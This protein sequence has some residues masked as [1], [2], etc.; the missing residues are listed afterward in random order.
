MP[1]IPDVTSLG[2]RPTPDS[3]RGVYRP[4]QSQA[5]RG[6]M[7]AG[8]A[9]QNTGAELQ[10]NVDKFNY[11][12]AKSDYLTKSLELDTQ[13]QNDTD[14]KTLPDRY[15][16]AQ[17]NIQSNILSQLPDERLRSELSLE[18]QTDMA[19]Q[20]AAIRQRANSLWKE[21]ELGQAVTQNDALKKAYARTK[22]P[23]YLTNVKERWEGLRDV[24]IISADVAAQ[25]M[26]SDADEMIINRGKVEPASFRAGLLN[27]FSS[28]MQPE[29]YAKA[30][31]AIS[32]VVDKLEDDGRGTVTYDT[33]GMTKYGISKKWNEDVDVENLTKE[34]AKKILK[35]RYWDAA[36]IDM[37]PD[38]MKLLVFDAAVNQGPE[39]ALTMA[40]MSGN[41]PEKFIGLRRSR[42][43]QLAANNPDTYGKYLKGW[44]NRLDKLSEKDSRYIPAGDVYDNLSPEKIMALAESGIADQKSNLVQTIRSEM[45]FADDNV[46]RAAKQQYRD[47]S[48]VVSAIEAIDKEL[49]DDP[50]GYAAQ[51][52]AMIE[53]YN[54]L[55]ES[56]SP[57]AR[58]K[59]FDA[60][61]S[62]QIRQGVAEQNVRYA[63]KEV[64][65][66]FKSTVNSE[67]ATSSSV[68]K[69]I[70]EIKDQYGSRYPH[71]LGEIRDA[72]ITGPYSIAA[73]LAGSG[74][75][76]DLVEAAQLGKE[77]L[78][79][80]VPA[81]EDTK[82]LRA[83]V[84]G[85]I[86]DFSAAINFM[87]DGPKLTNDFKDAVELLALRNMA[88]GMSQSEALDKAV[89]AV[90]PYEVDGTLVVPKG[91][92]ITAVRQASEDY[93]SKLSNM[94][95]LL[96]P[97]FGDK[98]TPQ[99][100]IYIN[101]IKNVNPVVQGDKVVF[102][103]PNKNPVL[104]KSKVRYFPGTTQIANAD[105]AM[106]S[107]P[108]SDAISNTNSV[109]APQVQESIVSDRALLT[110]AMNRDVNDFYKVGA[111]LEGIGSAS[112][113][114]SLPG[115]EGYDRLHILSQPVYESLTPE[116]KAVAKE[117][118]EAN[119][120]YNQMVLFRVPDAQK[121]AFKRYVERSNAVAENYHFYTNQVPVTWS[122]GMSGSQKQTL[123]S[124]AKEGDYLKSIGYQFLEVPEWV[125]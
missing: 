26:I 47:E 40:A 117:K 20:N 43:E 25:K 96:P 70:N 2:A 116:Q 17:R 65:E 54:T 28:P 51:S 67:N 5:G 85:K 46:K 7:Q 101:G 102:Y 78:T 9:L 64:I 119:V 24:G 118:I 35:E 97:E 88:D 66:D 110:H 6:L 86:E 103:W 1:R 18:L 109:S 111:K 79:A 123:R 83:A 124:K 60:L 13:F 52:P 11:A 76:E 38:N 49:Q 36:N 89:D 50:A 82:G 77:K 95:I 94:N 32:F 113:L 3:G 27:R 91:V 120:R 122:G 4:P 22:D 108:L 12:K 98:A 34:Q 93:K 33:G 73:I 80:A 37:L 115:D 45:R 71:V 15:N 8:A 75:V 62:E 56:D 14:Y 16:E 81:T 105:E 107:L 21:D 106:I 63:P 69:K 42:Y 61:R 114:I 58:E 87:P 39:T 112:A 19:R 125:K 121:D 74:D 53:A 59:Y 90:V 55:Q 100:D 72:G 10:Q 48:A 41:D 104:D 30:E 68:I 99:S 29:K 23:K 57:E 31:D 84:D 92:N 44:N